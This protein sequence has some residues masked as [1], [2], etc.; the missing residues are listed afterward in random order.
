MNPARDHLHL[1][2]RRHFFKSTGVALGRVALG[3]LM[4]PELLKG[5]TKSMTRAH[6]T[7]PGLPHFA[8]KARRIVHF[9]ID[10]SE[11]HK[12][13]R[14]DWHHVGLLPNALDALEILKS[15]EEIDLLFTDIVM[16]GG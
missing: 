7:L 6:P 2:S 9:Y 10:P 12:V 4:F 5:A 14:A 8:P 16:P 13:K 15:E 11:I 1:L 3:G